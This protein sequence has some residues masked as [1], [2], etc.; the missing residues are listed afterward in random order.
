[1]TVRACYPE[2]KRVCETICISYNKQYNVNFNIAR[3]CYIYGPTI[4]DENSR[5]DAQFLRKA[6]SKE[7]IVMKSE[8]KQKRTYCYVAD[9]V[10]ALLYILL[11][12]KNNE[13]YNIAN[14]DS[15]VSVREYAQILADLSGVKLTFE[16]P[17]EV[18]KCGY[19]KQADSRLSAQKL[20][21]I[22]WKPLYGI[23]DGLKR[24]ISLKKD[25]LNVR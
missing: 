6:I 10:S 19:S 22:G 7:D 16:L 20:M 25:V 8:G 18:E 24:T 11:N 14:P 12:G 23:K 15:I 5:A 21:N 13:V 3:L 17:D 4:T 2:A 1:M 9:A